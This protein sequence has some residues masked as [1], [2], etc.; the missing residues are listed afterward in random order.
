L[1]KIKK[2]EIILRYF[3]LNS[4]NF[5]SKQKR[6]ILYYL[7]DHKKLIV[8]S[9]YKKEA[10]IALFYLIYAER[11]IRQAHCTYKCVMNTLEDNIRAFLLD[12]DEVEVSKN[13]S[14]KSP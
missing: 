3:K 14:P 12:D 11:L 8:K 13:S 2:I 5:S 1:L 7:R 10:K 4:V 6:R 9:N